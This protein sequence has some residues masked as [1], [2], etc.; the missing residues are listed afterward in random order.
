MTPERLNALLDGFTGRHI[1]VVGD[2]MIDRY[3]WGKVDRV[4]PEAPVPVVDVESE[5]VRLGGA[6]NVAHNIQSLGGTPLLVGLVGDDSAAATLRSI[7]RERNLDDAGIITDPSRPTTVKTRVIAHDQHVV[8]IDHES[9][10]PCSEALRRALTGAVRACAS[11]LEGVILEDYNKGVFTPG[12]IADLV[13]LAHTR[14]IPVTVDP[15]FNHF[16]EYRGVTVFKPNRREAEEVLGIRLRTTADVEGAGH[17]LRSMLEAENVLL[18]RG[19]QGMSLFERDGSV[20][21]LSTTAERVHDVSGA[22]D[23]VIATLTMALVAGASFREAAALANMAGGLVVGEV[24]IVPV[25]PDRLRTAALRV[26]T[27]P[28]AAA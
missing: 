6:A 13:S 27:A 23:T 1:A 10:A 12:V 15:K 16:R 7:L 17:T 25:R 21:H 8:R 9:R 20:T 11:S 19:E 3:T 2:I 28:G 4:S 22:G 5:S 26:L 14:G 18:T 24:G